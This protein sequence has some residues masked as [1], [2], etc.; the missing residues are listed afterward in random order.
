MNI[1]ALARI[2]AACAT[3]VAAG[4]LISVQYSR[5]ALAQGPQKAYRPFQAQYRT[6]YFAGDGYISRTVVSDYARFS[7]RT[8]IRAVREIFPSS[9]DMGGTITRVDA[10]L[11]VLWE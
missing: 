1:R 10:G 4:F 3:C 6:D 2:T 8:T 9:T 7:N 11:R 5:Y